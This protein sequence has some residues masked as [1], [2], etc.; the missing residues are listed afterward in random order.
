[1]H[2]KTISFEPMH[3]PHP[4]LPQC[5]ESDPLQEDRMCLVRYWLQ[6]WPLPQKEVYFYYSSWR[7]MLWIRTLSRMRR[8]W[9]FFSL[10]MRLIWIKAPAS[11]F[12][13]LLTWIPRFIWFF[14]L[15]F[16]PPAFQVFDWYLLL[17]S[18]E[19]YTAVLP[20]LSPVFLCGQ[21][22]YIYIYLL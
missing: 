12:A 3:G 8:H 18:G 2:W 14:F 20:C 6:N 10:S 1:M 16:S 5:Y 17:F 13:S 19:V 22:S 7:N 9:P 11:V 15:V 21:V 4:C